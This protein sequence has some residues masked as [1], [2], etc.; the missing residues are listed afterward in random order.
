MHRTDLGL[1]FRAQRTRI[2][3]ALSQIEQAVPRVEVVNLIALYA[4]RRKMARPPLEEQT[5]LR[6]HILQQGLT[7]RRRRADEAPTLPLHC[8]V[9]ARKLADR[10]LASG[11]ELRQRKGL[12]LKAGTVVNATPIAAPSSTKNTTRNLDL[13]LRQAEKVNQC[14]ASGCRARRAYSGAQRWFA[15]RMR[16]P[17]RASKAY[18]GVEAHS[19]LIQTVRRRRRSST[20]SWA[21]TT[22]ATCRGSTSSPTPAIRAWTSDLIAALLTALGLWR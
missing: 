19:G 21:V 9:E 18:I 1:H 20:M 22:C 14:G 5:G 11:N 2:P 6:I 3:E 12:L 17:F 8:L 10:I 13:R 15:S 16:A 7:L 4:Q